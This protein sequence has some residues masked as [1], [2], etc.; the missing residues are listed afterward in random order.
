VNP[1]EFDAFAI[2]SRL[3][4]ALDAAGVPYAIGGAIAYGLWGDPRGTHDVDLNLFVD[5]DGLD[6]ALDVLEAAGVVLDRDAAHR[7]DQEGDVIVGWC[8]GMRVD[9]FT[10][11]I[12]FAWEAMKTR[13][14][15]DGPL[16]PATY[17]SAE[18][19]AV[20]KL[21]F[22]RS[23][24]RVDLEK[25]V[26]VQGADLDAAYVRRWMVE[27]MGEDDVRVRTWDALLAAHGPR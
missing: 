23:K 11:S 8:E 6:A 7:A 15:M 13:V 19:T 2:A 26:V 10:P 24:D 1:L 12:P 21:L 27:M 22:F 5:H 17:L 14:R 9:L 4:A 20:F 18:A 16:G 3:A 25:L